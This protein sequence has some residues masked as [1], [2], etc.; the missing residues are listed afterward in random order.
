MTSD[1]FVI[2]TWLREEGFREQH[3]RDHTVS[4]RIA[5]NQS[6]GDNDVILEHETTYTDLSKSPEP[7]RTKTERYQITASLLEALIRKHG[8]RL[9]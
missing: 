8:T 6:H 5:P 4:L 3:E 1:R 2:R 9:P 7:W